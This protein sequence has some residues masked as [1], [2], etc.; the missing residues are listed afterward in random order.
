MIGISHALNNIDLLNKYTDFIKKGKAEVL[1]FSPQH[2]TKLHK[3]RL[4]LILY[5][6]TIIFLVAVNS[7]DDK[8]YVS[9]PAGK[10]WLFNST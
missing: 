10:S 2:Q 6:V 4:A 7:L 9:T 5:F 8:V 1:D 3:L